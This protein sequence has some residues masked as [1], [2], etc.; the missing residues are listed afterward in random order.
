MVNALNVFPVPDGDT[1]TNMLATLGEALGEAEGAGEDAA[2]RL[3]RGA[4]LGARGNSGVILSQLLRAQVEVLGTPSRP[5]AGAPRQTG[6][7]AASASPLPAGSAA[8]EPSASLA[9]PDLAAVLARAR[10]LAYQAV[11]RPVP[12]TML[13]LLDALAQP[14]SAASLEAFL[15]ESL[16]RAEAALAATPDQLPILREAGMVDSGGYGLL[17]V[18]QGWH[19][20]LTGKPA[21]GLRR[22]LLGLAR[23]RDQAAAGLG[24]PSAHV[25]AAPS[26]YGSCV[27]LLV[28]APAA[29]EADIREGLQAMGDSV[30]VVAAGGQVKLHVHVAD[31]EQAAAFAR[32]F[33]PVVRSEV[34]NIDEQTGLLPAPALPVV[35][36]ASGAGLLEV[37]R[38]LGA[39]VVDGGQSHN[40]SPAELLAACRAI[41]GP[42][43]LLPNDPNAI[44]AAQQAAAEREEIF[45]VP[46]R[47]VPQGVAAALAYDRDAGPEDNL[48]RMSQAAAAVLTATFAHAG[49][50]ATLNGIQVEPG[51]LM[52]LLDGQLLGVEEAGLS[53]LLSSVADRQPELATIYFGAGA[54]QGEAE[55]VSQ[56]LQASLPALEVEIV[57]GDQPRE[58]FIISFE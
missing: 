13:S 37:F 42:V 49:R 41:S 12:G 58:A 39:A 9:A 3:A 5:A 54:L 18:L 34:S 45:A 47:S 25:P 19:E 21:P 26:R 57:R 55:R 33:G 40:P 2:E 56:Q 35:A 14:S 16:E 31:P 29:A 11:S 53:A 30:L 4:I 10:E 50:A 44:A 48:A 32:R 43:F 15:G 24:R 46:T 52:V 20:A 17:L 28:D 27:T 38:G 6:G 7:S 23:A 36:V 51:Q 8:R 22:D 1:G